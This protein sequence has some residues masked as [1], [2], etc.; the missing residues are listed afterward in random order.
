MRWFRSNLRGGGLLALFALALQ[1]SLSFAHIHARDA[2]GWP[3]APVALATIAPA[4]AGSADN[5]HH[6]HGK[7]DVVCDI[8]ATLS[9]A[10]A[11]QTPSAPHVAPPDFALFAALV[12]PDE[13]LSAPQPRRGFRSRAPPAV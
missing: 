12:G 2:A 10:A 3:M 7:L 6:P 5:G 13:A 11:A 9:I 4:A 8:C 1:F